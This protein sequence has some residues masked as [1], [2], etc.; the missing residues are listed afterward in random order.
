M[1][2]PGHMGFWGF[3]LMSLTT[4]LLWALLITGIVLLVRYLGRSAPAADRG[5]PERILAERY[6]RGDIDEQEYRQRLQVLRGGGST[7]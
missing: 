2:C 1:Y 3:G 5:S 7:A 6:A 4:L